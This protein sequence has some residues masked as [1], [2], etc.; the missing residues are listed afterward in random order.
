MEMAIK[1]P[2]NNEV[3]PYANVF[4]VQ[5]GMDDFIIGLGLI[6]PPEIETREDLERIGLLE[7]T[8]IIR[9]AVSRRN[10]EKFIDLLQKQYARQT[11]FIR[12]EKENETDFSIFQENYSITKGESD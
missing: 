11:V 2:E 3:L 1:F 4:Q 8:P 5:A 10:M 7:A 9:I 12:M 6:V